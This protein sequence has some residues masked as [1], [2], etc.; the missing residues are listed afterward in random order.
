MKVKMRRVGSGV[1]A[2]STFLAATASGTL[3]CA[4]EAGD[5]GEELT[6]EA[7][8][9]IM[10]AGVGTL[11]L[12]PTS[13]N[14]VMPMSLTQSS[15]DEY[16]RAGELINFSLPAWLLWAT[17]YPY[18]AVPDVARLSQL[19]VS[20]SALSYDASAV[21]VGTL[22]ATKA[23]ASGSG[24]Y[25]YRLISSQ[26]TI[27]SNAYRLGFQIN[28]TD[29]A[30]A[31]ASATITASQTSQ[32]AVFGGQLPSR[33]ILFDSSYSSFRQRTLEGDN[34]VAGK[35]ITFAYTD[36]RA[37]TLVDRSTIDTQI[38]TASYAGRF[39]WTTV[40][41]YG[42]IVHEVSY[43][44]Y[45]NDGQGWRSEQALTPNTSS[46]FLPQ[47]RTAYEKTFTVP[48]NATQ[49]SMYMHVKTYLVADYTGYQNV[50]AWYTPGSQNLK[51]E[52]WDNP[53]GAYTNYDYT[54]DR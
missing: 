24:Q 7:D 40:P 16:V 48:S 5:D 19:N 10:V 9:A 18:D 6:A 31:S 41:I 47:G 15:T 4:T 26:I 53:Y 52:A 39:G 49:M 33:D 32:V 17:L 46:R 3:G 43:G 13:G 12:Q 45:F 27:P 54:V 30:N 36:W 42:K 21:L 11:E 37:D 35:D 25:D 1:A 50:N 22:T 38:G 28:I 14:G 2:A 34:P 23:G 29:A 8:S 51:R 44:I 20:V